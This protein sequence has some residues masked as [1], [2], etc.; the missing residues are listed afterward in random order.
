MY[1]YMYINVCSRGPAAAGGGGECGCR[2]P[3]A[4]GWLPVACISISIYTYIYIY[5]F[6]LAGCRLSVAGCRLRGWLSTQ[7]PGPL[8]L[9]LQT[10][11]ACR[12]LT[13]AKRCPCAMAALTD[14]SLCFVVNSAWALGQELRFTL[15]LW[16]LL[17]ALSTGLSMRPPPAT[18]PITA[19]H[20]E[21][22]VLREP[23]GR[24]MRVFLPSSEWPTTMHLGHD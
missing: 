23:E 3:V 19:R 14:S 4:G 22:I 9:L 20:V 11:R 12:S 1:M 16:K 8:G 17:P 21:G 18:R 10:R 2:L 5:M 7:L 13:I 15:Y 6:V 24:R